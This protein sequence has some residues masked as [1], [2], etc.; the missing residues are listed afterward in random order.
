M[1]KRVCRET[2][3]HWA[4]LLLGR[5]LGSMSGANGSVS[6]YCN[7]FPEI[8]NLR[9]TVYSEHATWV[10][11][12]ALRQLVFPFQRK[13]KASRGFEPRSL[14]SESRVLTVT[15]RGQVKSEVIDVRSTILY[16]SN[17]VFFARGPRGVR[18]WRGNCEDCNFCMSDSTFCS[19]CF[20]ALCALR[21]YGFA[22][23]LAG[24]HPEGWC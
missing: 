18:L 7:S 3:C 4:P 10:P 9:V 6:N 14:D 1:K 22:N 2:L 16:R 17:M 15:P 23:P 12:G 19:W 5:V 24:A 21:G 11:C 20:L 13:P 8:H